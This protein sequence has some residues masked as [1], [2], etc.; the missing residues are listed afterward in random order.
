MPLY[1]GVCETNITPP[2]GVAMCGYAYR[3]H[4]CA[5]IHDELYARALVLDDGHKAVAIL[6]MD[7]IGLD[8]DL[9]AQVRAGISGQAGLAPEAMLLSAT[10]THGGPVTRTFNAMGPRDA[11]YCD[12]LVRKL[13]GVTKQA[14]RHMQPASLAYGHAP[15]QI[16]INRRR[17]GAPGEPT[18]I[19]RNFAG[20]VM[21]GVEAL[22]V[23][24]SRN[25]PFALL[26][27]HACHP[28][29]LG[30]DNLEVTADFCGYACDRVKQ[31]TAGSVLPFFLQGCG[32]N[33]NPEPRGSFAWAARHG[34]TLGEAA[35]EALNCATSL[36][37]HK[38]D[39]A[40]T[41]M[42]LPVLAPPERTLCEETREEW[43]R[44]EKEALAR[45]D[46]SSALFAEGMQHYAAFELEALGAPSPT[47]TTDFA[48]QRLRLG[49]A[50]FLGLP[51][52][53]FVQYALDFAQ[54]AE[55]QY[56]GPVFSLAY[57]NG[58][59]GYVPIAAD[60]PFGGYEVDSAYR[61]Y[62]HLMFTPDCE[63]LIREAVYPLL[64][65]SNPLRVPYSIQSAGE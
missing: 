12:L 30:G 48:I 33:I 28:T 47:Q 31:K 59:H 36:D 39:F 37:S 54:Q 5:A 64:G 65:I 18:Y 20:P 29:T 17:Y 58:I 32:G 56:G 4:G 27:S 1:A 62:Q 14:M 55:K 45:G 21:P 44:K 23:R 10:H 13:V 22:V 25:H 2:L 63:R 11:A 24:D 35:I 8:F 57:A 6:S 38:L 53:M 3:P 49:K 34:E 50:Q 46:S 42:P 16:G 51:G 52:E 43:R 19:G 7:L 61:F 40:E 15:V 60:Y 41:T 9:V 26:F